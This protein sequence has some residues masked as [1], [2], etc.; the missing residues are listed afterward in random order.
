MPPERRRRFR[1]ATRGLAGSSPSG[2]PAPFVFLDASGKPLAVGDRVAQYP[3][4]RVGA[5]VGFVRR[6][7]RVC[8]ID[9]VYLGGRASKVDQATLYVM[10]CR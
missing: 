9:R 6:R 3:Q 4:G 1:N 5:V 10:G 2:E 7:V 8:W